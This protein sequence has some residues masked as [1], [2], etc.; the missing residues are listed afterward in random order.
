MKDRENSGQP[1]GGGNRLSVTLTP[2]QRDAIRRVARENQVSTAWVI[3]QAVDRYLAAQTP[4][5]AATEE[6]PK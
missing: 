2:E 5:F 6:R 1:Q 4:L 3:R